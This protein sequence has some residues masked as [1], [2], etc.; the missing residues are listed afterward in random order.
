MWLLPRHCS[1]AKN[2]PA[3]LPPLDFSFPTMFFSPISGQHRRGQECEWKEGHD[4]Y[5]S[6]FLCVGGQEK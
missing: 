2:F 6:L 3:L 4:L 1:L 5:C